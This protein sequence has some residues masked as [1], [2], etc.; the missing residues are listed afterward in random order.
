MPSR[1][2]L[3]VERVC[4]RECVCMCKYVCCGIY[5]RVREQREKEAGRKRERCWWRRVL[6]PSVHYTTTEEI[7]L[8]M[9]TT[10][11]LM[12]FIPPS[13]PLHLLPFNQSSSLNST[14]QKFNENKVRLSKERNGKAAE[15]FGHTGKY[16]ETRVTIVF[17]EVFLLCEGKMQWQVRC[18]SDA[19]LEGMQ[20][21]K[22]PPGSWL[23]PETTTSWWTK[24]GWYKFNLC[25]IKA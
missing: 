2:V 4:V 8:L 16:T 18:R 17:E 3:I 23:L 13:S 25:Y 15:W 14:S 19:E 24:K 9:Q 6:E 1:V 12:L 22:I 21:L 20:G 7:E 5:G 10:G 11:P